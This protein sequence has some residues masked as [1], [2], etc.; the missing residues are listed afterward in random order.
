M[1]AFLIRPLALALAVFFIPAVFSQETPADLK[2][3]PADS[4]A[5]AHIRIDELWKSESLKDVRDLML[6]A[7]PRALLAF[8]KRFAIQ[9]SSVRSVSVFALFA[10]PIPDFAIMVSFAQ[11]VDE[12]GLMQSA[13]PEGKTVTK[14]G[15]S[16]RMD[17]RGEFGLAILEG[18][19]L[20]AVGTPGALA[21]LE[22]PGVNREDAYGKFLSGKMTSPILAAVNFAAI[23]AQLVGS[24]PPPLSPLVE[25]AELL[26]L[27]IPSGKDAEI[28]A[29]IVYKK[30]DQAAASLDALK[31][32]A[33]M[34]LGELVQPRREMEKAL[35]APGKPVPAPL[36]NLPE[37]AGALV[38]LAFLNE[39]E[40]QLKNPPI[41]QKGNRLDARVVLPQ[42]SSNAMMSSWAIGAALMLPA[43]QKVRSAANRTQSM[44]NLKQIA[45]A[46]H[47]YNDVYQGFPSAAICDANGKP[48]LSWRVAILPFIDQDNLYKQ[49]KLD[50]PWDSPNNKKLI[51]IMPKVYFHPELNQQGDTKTHYRIFYGNGAAFE[52]TKKTQLAKIPDGT[53]NTIMA[54]EAADSVE[55]TK[56]E[57]FP[58]DPKGNL[59]KMANVNGGFNASLCDGSVRFISANIQEKILKL[60]IQG[61]DG[62][63]IPQ[64]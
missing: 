28:R 5:M 35:F 50:E 25:G 8:D 31:S 58:F 9:F 4:L 44:N 41:T 19:K 15:I 48:L 54:V 10:M 30:D 46:M 43:V 6:K 17:G 63:V 57:E 11:P 20:V 32:L 13:F 62:Q 21:R 1:K 42:I 14:G 64:F 37:A 59:P 49:F 12:K 60:L 22:K 55:W 3:V 45:L 34:A 39:V 23:P 56:P 53:S 24:L 47:N 2:R 16:I 27:E 40:N 61:N 18:G 26:V 36:A 38:G 7:G 33:T 51:A 29:R 52:L